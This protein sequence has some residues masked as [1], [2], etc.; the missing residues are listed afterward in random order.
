MRAWEKSLF[1]ALDLVQNNDYTLAGYNIKRF[2]IPMINRFLSSNLQSTGAISYAK[3]KYSGGIRPNYVMDA[4]VAERLYAPYMA[5]SDKQRDIAKEYNLTAHTQE[6][7]VRNY[8]PDFYD[9]AGAQ[10]HTSEIDVQAG[11]KL[12]FESGRYTPGHE[13]SI[14]PDKEPTKDIILS[15][16]NKQ[17]L[18]A[19]KSL[20]SV[21]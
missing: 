2:D 9:K 4:M 1:Q 14:I 8:F 10:A 19:P 20:P 12:L 15:G 16:G 3:Q 13:N 18:Y 17:L 5:I 21:P 6:A 7:L 11:A